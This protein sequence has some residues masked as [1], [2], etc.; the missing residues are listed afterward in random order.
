MEQLYLNLSVINVRNLLTNNFSNG[1]FISKFYYIMFT[2][3]AHCVNSAMRGG[4]FDTFGPKFVIAIS[5]TFFDRLARFL[6]W[7]L[8]FSRSTPI[9]S[10]IE[11][12]KSFEVT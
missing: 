7:W 4:D 11:D 12:W 5:S 2:V 8:V 1:K 10:K 6:A 3:Y 9:F